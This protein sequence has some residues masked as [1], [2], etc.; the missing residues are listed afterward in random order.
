[1]LDDVAVVNVILRRRHAG[2]QIESE[3]F[4]SFVYSCVSWVRNS[5]Q[6]F[7]Q[8][9]HPCY[10]PN[11]WLKF[12]LRRSRAGVAGVSSAFASGSGVTSRPRLIPEQCRR[13]ACLYRKLRTVDHDNLALVRPFVPLR[14][15]T[16]T[17][18]IISYIFPLLRITFV[19]SQNVVKKSRLPQRTLL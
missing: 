17:N 11:P 12:P 9:N 5:A 15:E 10:P 7:S 19:A 4:L 3:I 16:R 14:H 13:H 8:R 1:M 2:R 18:R 6:L